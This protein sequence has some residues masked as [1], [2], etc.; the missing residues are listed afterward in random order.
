MGWI[1]GDPME[2]STQLGPEEIKVE[3]AIQIDFIL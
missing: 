1:D 3:A 2:L